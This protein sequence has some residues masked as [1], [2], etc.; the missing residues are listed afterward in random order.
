MSPQ[1]STEPM[2][3]ARLA[4][5]LSS[6]RQPIPLLKEAIA[7]AR[8]QLSA[9]FTEAEDTELLI[10]DFTRFMDGIISLA[11]H[12]FTW[13]EKPNG[14]RK[15]R[16]SLLAVGGYGRCQLLP[17]SDID[18]LILLEEN[19]QA[20][21]RANI[22]S[23]TALLWDLGLNLAHS[24][25]TIE[26]CCRQ[27]TQNVTVLTAMMESRTLCGDDDLRL[28]A[29]RQLA[30]DKIWTPRQFFLAKREE[31]QARHA[32]SSHIEYRLEPNVKTSPGGLRDI[33][34]LAWVAK[35]QYG[36]EGFAELVDQGLLTEDE[37]DE[38][39]GSSAFLLKVRFALH[40][41]CERDENRLL[42]EYQQ[43]LAAQ[44]GY[45]DGDQLA[46][47]QFMQGYYRVVHRVST[48]NEI[49]LQHFDEVLVKASVPRSLAPINARFRLT[50]NYL[51]IT[52]EKV[53]QEAPSALLEMFVL[54]GADE[55]IQG[56]RASTIRRARQAVHLIDDAFRANP[57]HARLFMALL[58]SPYHLFTQ[59]RRMARYGI[60]GAYLPEFGRVVGQMQFDLFHIYTVDAHTLE[61]VRN[62][63]RF[64]YR[65]QEQRFPIA[66]NIHRQLP[67]VELLYIAG[68][69]HDIAK[70]MGG[71][72]STLGATITRAFCE[73]HQLPARETDLVCWLVTHHLVMS[74]TAQRKDTQDPQVIHEFAVLVGN[75]TRLDY[76]YALTVADINATNPTL[77]NGWRARLLQDLYLHTR[78]AL[79]HGS[80]EQ[81][82]RSGYAQ[83][84]QQEVLSRFTG[85][86]AEAVLHLWE[87]VDDD[88]FVRERVADITWHTEEILARGPDESPLILIQDA[89]TRQENDGF[90]RIF[91]HTK[92]RKDLFVSILTALDSFRLE[93]VEAGIATSRAD[94]TFNTFTILGMDRQPV[95]RDPRITERIKK[96]I[97]QA[98]V[99]EDIKPPQVRRTPRRLVPFPMK[100]EVN[101]RQA[102]HLA[103]SVLEVSA[104]DRPGL[105]A[106]IAKVL[107]EGD[108]NLVT[109]K[110]TTLGERVEDIFYITDQAGRP[111]T[112]P[113]QQQ[114]LHDLLQAGMREA[115]AL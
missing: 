33:Q 96:T 64:R 17:H 37:R 85:K 68:L 113:Q 76:L 104:P 105:L 86:Q 73:R 109:A 62:M 80:E 23:F 101:I 53:F 31:Q 9:R 7:Q 34:T 2:Q 43:R 28:Q 82:D 91:I 25:R 54:M 3:D 38:L 18:L 48:I 77:W 63:R 42:F 51:E 49:L 39:L 95:S 70:G 29:N 78:K 75:Q 66:A 59:L 22:Q 46:V 108:I 52:S 40:T 106:V 93:V 45:R 115:T 88:Y 27:A 26:D 16:I 89:K 19:S 87:D 24:V 100:T 57:E 30:I 111:I 47:E 107:V 1:I 14:G 6:T 72:H 90:T 56:I 21:H 98:V 61:V 50:N 67:R 10:A 65:N 102:P 32:K 71:D 81:R 12:R 13:H 79:R 35:R 11:W 99:A 114:S 60:L 69:Y 20:L 110:I 36:T 74:T 112:D 8:A 41:L 4:D 94:M 84:I 58:G 103:Q 44:F 15:S 92:D 83:D 55:K 5:R 97:M